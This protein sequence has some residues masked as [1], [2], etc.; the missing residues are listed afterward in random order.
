MTGQELIDWIHESHA[1]NLEF[2]FI[3]A[4]G[5][6]TR[7]M[8][9]IIDNKEIKEELWEGYFLPDEGKCVVL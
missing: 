2:I 6:V 7:I 5:F 8:P 4:D 1:E 9:E 3:Q